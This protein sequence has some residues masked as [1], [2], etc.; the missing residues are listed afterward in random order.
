MSDGPI[1]LA[2]LS[3]D[4]LLQ[5]AQRVR[6]AGEGAS[7]MEAVAQGIVTAVRS[8]VRGSDGGESLALVR[9]YVTQR[10]GALEPALQAFAVQAAPADAHDEIDAD[11]RCFTLLATAGALEEWNDRRRSVEHQAIP[12]VREDLVR[13]MPMVAGLLH[14][15]G[16]DVASVVRPAADGNM[17]RHH[18]R[19]DVFHVEDAPTSPYVPAKQFVAEHGIRSALG[20]GGVLPSG[21]LYCLLLFSRVPISARAADL[22]SSLAVTVKATVV[23]H[24]FSVFSPQA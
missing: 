5:V 18:R 3:V 8:C 9:F 17:E 4:D 20:L 6:A 16:V 13:R 15:L 12:L 10:F 1:D 22:L 2:R 19:Y 7:G 24:T 14:A 11:T 21:E 23:P